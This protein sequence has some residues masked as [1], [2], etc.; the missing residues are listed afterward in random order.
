MLEE[1][2]A[3]QLFTLIVQVPGRGAATAAPGRNVPVRPASTEG[4]GAPVA[5]SG[6][7]LEH[8]RQGLLTLHTILSTM[9]NPLLSA[10]LARTHVREDGNFMNPELANESFVAH[11]P[12]LSRTQPGDHSSSPTT[13][14]LTR[15]GPVALEME[16]AAHDRAP[17]MEVPSED[18]LEAAVAVAAAR[19]RLR[20][21]LIR[22]VNQTSAATATQRLI[23]LRRNLAAAAGPA[24][25]DDRTP[26]FFAGQ[27]VDVEDTV[28]QWL[29]ATVMRVRGR[30]MLV[31][32]LAPQ[33]TSVNKNS[34]RI[35]CS[36]SLQRLANPLG[37][38]DRI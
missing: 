2:S 18:A 12:T 37:R 29:E 35:F 24:D 28:H 16:Q 31:F 1:T 11:S 22:A 21:S 25:P 6:A 38:V 9:Q 27:W 3:K 33:E 19:L 20:Q 7:S 15:P 36:G 32:G 26:T 8:V 23:G 30:R 34:R 13:F 17:N 14:S 5:G 10:N 4:G